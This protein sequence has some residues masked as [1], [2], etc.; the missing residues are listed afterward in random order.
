MAR[1]LIKNTKRFDLTGNYEGFHITLMVDPAMH[2]WDEFQSG[3][4]LRI[5]A[6]VAALTVESD[7]VDY[8]DV[9][10]D[11]STIAGWHKMPTSLL[12]VVMTLLS[13]ALK[14]DPKAQANSNGSSTRSVPEGASSPA[15]TT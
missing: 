3:E 5:L 15:S 13:E 10:T 11:L 4:F 12:K 9:P 1:S 8:D 2:V 7:L 14:D 6:A